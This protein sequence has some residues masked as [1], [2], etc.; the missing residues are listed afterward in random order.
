[1]YGFGGGGVRGKRVNAVR[2]A[3]A[4]KG[5]RLIC[6]E[7][8]DS[9]DTGRPVEVAGGVLGCSAVSGGVEGGKTE[10]VRGGI[11]NDLVGAA[12]APLFP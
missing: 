12:L 9:I 7:F 11:G 3:V 10:D 5:D 1:M 6:L 8:A 4:V 2:S